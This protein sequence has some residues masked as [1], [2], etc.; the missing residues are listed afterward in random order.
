MLFRP[1]AVAAV[2]LVCAAAPARAAEA[3]DLAALEAKGVKFKKDK[4]GVVT[5]ASFGGKT[6]IDLDGW[7]AVGQIKS[8]TKAS[9]SGGSNW[10]PGTVAPPGDPLN[11]QTAAAIA[12]LENVEEF[13]SNGSEMTDDAFKA[14]AGWKK[15][16]R[17]GLDHW[18]GPKSSKATLGPGLAHL[19]D[20]PALEHVRLGGCK[21]DNRVCDALAQCK[22]L[23]SVDLFHTFAVTDDGVAALKALPK[24]RVVKLGPQF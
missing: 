23:Q 7:K 17:F 3:P 6:A 11:D 1:I 19:K 8:I 4:A 21:V 20:L 5:E 15:L 2:A 13:F 16:R 10:P 9:F 12:G 22:S 14:F 24:L 18:F